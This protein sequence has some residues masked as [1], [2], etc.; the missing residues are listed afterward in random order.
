MRD[1]SIDEL[2]SM[3]RTRTDLMNEGWTRAAIDT[4]LAGGGIHRLRRGWYVHGQEWATLWPQARHRAL[5]IAGAEDARVPPVYCFTSAATLLGLPVHPIAPGRVHMAVTTQRRSV[6]GVVRHRTPLEASDVVEIGGLRCTSI[7]RTVLDIARYASPEVAIACADAAL[8][9]IGGGPRR[10][11]IESAEIWRDGLRGLLSVPGARG[12]RQARAVL[13]MADGRSELPLESVTKLQLRRL[14]FAQP[15]LQV[16]LASPTGTTYWMD[17]EIEEAG[18]FYECD[19]EGKYTDET[20]R[21]GRSVERVILD[22]KRREDWVRGV[23]GKRV[24]R[25]GFA[26]VASPGAL[27][28][29]LTAFGIRLPPIRKRLLLPSRPALAGQ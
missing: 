7:S 13:D 19:G 17:M 22:E 2:R 23:T 18:V 12:V 21:S 24:L 15:K 28:A 10:Y 11:H 25:G 1:P 8:S 27:A 14:G 26:E 29:R 5:L 6:P 3:L 9:S 16:P 4:G 20:L